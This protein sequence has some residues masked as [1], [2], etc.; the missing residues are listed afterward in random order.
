M[1]S[2]VMTV[3]KLNG[4]TLPPP[5]P[6]SIFS[7][8]L[9]NPKEDYAL[10]SKFLCVGVCSSLVKF[11]IWVS[12]FEKSDYN[13]SCVKDAIGVPSYCVNEVKSRVELFLSHLNLVQ[14]GLCDHSFCMLCIVCKCS[15]CIVQLLCMCSILQN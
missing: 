1:T 7:P 10:S 14:K 3:L 6:P 8:G 11:V 15:M 2:D 13:Q 5:S 12:F 4:C 9:K